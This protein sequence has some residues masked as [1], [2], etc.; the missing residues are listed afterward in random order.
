MNSSGLSK[1][2]IESILKESPN[3]RNCADPFRENEMCICGHE[4]KY[5]HNHKDWEWGTYSICRQCMACPWVGKQGECRNFKSIDQCNKEKEEEKQRDRYRKG[6]MQY[7][8]EKCVHHSGYGCMRVK[9]RKYR[10]KPKCF[11]KKKS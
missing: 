3:I 9:Y 1:E 10:K 4:E 8:C 5:H 11:K 6:L 2:E 7:W